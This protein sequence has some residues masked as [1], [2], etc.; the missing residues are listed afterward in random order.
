MEIPLLRDLLIVLGLSV[1]ILLVSN[2]VGIPPMVGLLL[3]GVIVGPHGLALLHSTHEVE[4]MAEVGVVL[5]LFT[6]GME[7]S[8]IKLFA[9]GKLIISGG[10]LQ[11]LLTTAA[12]VLGGMIVGLTIPTSIHIGF[13]VSLS[14]TAIVLKTLQERTE[15][16]SPHGRLVL[17]ILICQDIAIVPMILATPMLTGQGG[18]GPGL[19][20]ALV[21]KIVGVLVFVWLSMKFAV[22]WLLDQIAGTRSRELFILTIVV[23]CFAIAWLTS[24]IG[25]SLGLGAFLAGLILSESPYSHNSLGGILPFRDVFTSL[26]F[27]SIGMLLD[28]RFLVAHPLLILAALAAI[29]IVKAIIVTIGG[30]LL[31]YPL[32]NAAHAGIALAQVGE[33]S[34]VLARAGVAA[35]LIGGDLYQS[36][37]ATSVLTMAMT[38]FLLRAAP[39]IA[40]MIQRVSARRDARVQDQTAEIAEP[41]SNHIVIIG[42]GFTGANIARAARAAGIEYVII[43]SNPETVRL[44]KQ[45][46]EPIT[47]G[48]AS[49]PSVLEHAAVATA[50]I[51]AVVINDPVATRGIIQTVRSISPATHIIVRTRFMREIEAL[52][53]LG[54]SEIIPEEFETS[55]ELSSRILARC[56]VP[57]E[58]I[59][60]LIDRIRRDEY[61]MYRTTPDLA[62]SIG[63]PTWSLDDVEVAAIEIDRGSPLDG[64]TLAEIDLRRRHKVTLLEIRRAERRIPNPGGDERLSAGDVIMVV[65]SAKRRARLARMAGS[66][67]EGPAPAGEHQQ[68]RRPKS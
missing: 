67:T 7:F 65:G 47:F 20:L 3:T 16:E 10:S 58:Q 12:V 4:V 62:A 6:I 25:L 41:V 36:F 37:L 27:V 32:R 26:F 57:R 13:L 61:R 18:G 68:Q 52:R 35:G 22:P 1:G 48:D 63:D 53:A 38:P 30:L 23:I 39:D 17:A 56:L 2:R 5:L 45:R 42:F 40:G 55:I 8:L 19:A 28:V 50:R 46:G 54:A 11:I 21:A 31:G 59:A 64:R 66:P 29:I 34:F 51:V 49:Y 14:S 15:I 60:E 9:I 44:E 24:S 43:E 33:F